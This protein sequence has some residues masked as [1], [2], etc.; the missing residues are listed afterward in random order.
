MSIYDYPELYAALFPPD[1]GLPEAVD[2]WVAGVLGAPPT[3]MLEVAC[4][5]GDWARRF[6]ERGARVHG[7]DLSPVMVEA[8]ERHLSSWGGTASVAD[9]R[10]VTLST[11]P[12][13]VALNLGGS[14]GHLRSDVEL[15]AHLQAMSHLIRVGGLYILG[16][17]VRDGVGVET[18]VQMLLET[19]PIPVSGGFAAVR[20]ESVFRD[21][22]QGIE[23]IRNIVLAKEVRDVPGPFIEEYDLRIFRSHSLAA[24]VESAGFK[25]VSAYSL[26]E[27]PR[28]DVGLVSDAGDVALI[29]QRCGD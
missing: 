24:M 15:A 11:P 14:V 1:D 27:S 7:F 28:R 4:G 21:H 9:M 20:V 19:N 12:F 2:E 13:D 8:A 5:R 18:D 6:A 25:A 10:D 17:C 3:S 16:L 29:L 22:N 23:R 26:T